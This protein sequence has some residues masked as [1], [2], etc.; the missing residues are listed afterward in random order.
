MLGYVSEGGVL[1][2]GWGRT[3]FVPF[4]AFGEG[5]AAA[6]EFVV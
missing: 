4:P 3:V 5:G 6:V 1:R 2:G